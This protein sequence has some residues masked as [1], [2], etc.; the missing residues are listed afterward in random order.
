MNGKVAV[1]ANDDTKTDDAKTRA[2]MIACMEHLDSLDPEDARRALRTLAVW[3]DDPDDRAN[4]ADSLI[5]TLSDIGR[6]IRGD[7]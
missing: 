2:A 7:E 1:V 5:E 6:A 4:L 3:F